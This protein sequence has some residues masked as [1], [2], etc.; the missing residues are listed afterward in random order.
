MSGCRIATVRMKSGGA[1]IRIIERAPDCELVE[2]IIEGAEEA[3]KIGA[4][5]MAMV[6]CNEN[7]WVSN[8]FF[9]GQNDFALVGAIED[10][11]SRI[12][13]GGMVEDD[14]WE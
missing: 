5:S 12:I 11:K 4:T 3:R 1:V 8:A 2:R 7:G 14:E 10:L 6:M 9:S 13:N